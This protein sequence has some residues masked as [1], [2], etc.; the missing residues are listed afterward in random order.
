MYAIRNKSNGLYLGTTQTEEGYYQSW[1]LSEN[2]LIKFQS[3][4]DAFDFTTFQGYDFLK[5]VDFEITNKEEQIT[6]MNVKESH[7]EAIILFR[8]VDKYKAIMEDTH[9]IVNSLGIKTVNGYILFNHNM[10]DEYLTKI[11]QSGF[12]VAVVDRELVFKY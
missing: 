8:I 10:L 2:N 7:P 9:I 1:N 11:I 5:G 4:K 12:K 6:Y 3:E